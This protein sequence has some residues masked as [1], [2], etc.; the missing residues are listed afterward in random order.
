VHDL[1]MVTRGLSL[2]AAAVT[3][4]VGVV[5]AQ[6]M[7]DQGDTPV[8]WF[9]FLLV[10]GAGASIVA[11]FAPRPRPFAVLAT[12][13]LVVSM[14]IS[15]LSVGILLL[16]AVIASVLTLIRRQVPVG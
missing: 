9:L 4:V 14:V 6:V 1:P 15:I 12:I 11:A 10:V 13:V 3:S 16:P 2:V 8:A 7:R 5:Y